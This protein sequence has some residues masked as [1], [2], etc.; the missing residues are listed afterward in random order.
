MGQN[1]QHK[2]DIFPQPLT[3]VGERG[4][5]GKQA[6]IPQLPPKV[7]VRFEACF[8]TLYGP[9]KLSGANN[10]PNFFGAS[11]ENIRKQA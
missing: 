10:S 8:G 2:S 1:S 3:E 4:Q 5:K 11:S 6:Q 7:E 9:L